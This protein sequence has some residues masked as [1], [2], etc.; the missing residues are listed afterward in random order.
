MNT[1]K[2]VLLAGLASAAFLAPQ[3][4]LGAGFAS[5]AQSATATGMA[6][7]A[8][9]N[10]DEPN[11]NFYNP[12]SM[13]FREDF[14]V[15][16]GLTL[17]IPSVSF[18]GPD[19]STAETLS[20]IFPPPNF[21]LTVPFAERF[22]VGLG[23]TLPWGLGIAWPEDWE[24]RENFISQDLQT[25]N[26]NPNVAYRIPGINL[27]IAAGAQVMASA[28]RQERRI[29]LREDREV[30][31][32][33]GGQGYGVGA[34]FAVMY[35]VSDWTVGLNYRSGATL[36]YEGRAHFSGAEDTP[37]SGRF[38][39]QDITTS[40]TVPHTVNLG[41]GFRPMEKL[42]LSIEAN[43]MTWSDYDEV[44]VLFSEQSP[45]G[46][47]G[48]REPSLLVAADWQDALAFRI[49][50]EYELISDLKARIGF[51]F[52]MTPVPDETVG[53]SLPDNDR[54]VFAAG[55]GYTFLGARADL[56][57]QFVYLNPREIRNDT[58]NGTYQLSSHVVGLNIGYGF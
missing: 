49:G 53:P 42:F 35:Q 40:I 17:I 16:A 33:L 32:I 47:P 43:Y 13:V 54:F 29:I 46:E 26:V 4:A 25:L 3:T 58:V 24:G 11:A 34:T 18:E 44:E 36:N 10:P 19:G 38:V 31:V 7:T 6:G 56:G 51:A 23:V 21:S 12:A 1:T 5:T 27:G 15:S 30:D 55:I 50:G 41:V 52:D 28:L 37:F 57:Y 9:A 48:D 2:K 45:Q 14:N 39:D 8:V 20:Q 22:A